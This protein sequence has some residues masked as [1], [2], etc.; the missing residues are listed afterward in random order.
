M[1]LEGSTNE[2]GSAD[3]L[4]SLP[5]DDVLAYLGMQSERLDIAT[6]RAAEGRAVPAW[7]D[8][9]ALAKLVSEQRA[10]A[11]ELMRYVARGSDYSQAL[12]ARIR[13]G[14]R[15]L[16]CD[17][18]ALRPDIVKLETDVRELLKYMIAGIAGLVAANLPAALAAAATSI[19]T[20]IAI[21]LIK[22][23]LTT[24]CSLA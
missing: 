19:A 5:E 24:F 14:V 12:L 16:L 11:D 7:S 9:G 17:A 13:T 15:D 18:K 23:R 10:P 3:A 22:R 21:L 1:T 20:G 4:L 6:A 2:G 8:H